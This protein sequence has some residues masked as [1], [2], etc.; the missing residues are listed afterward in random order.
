MSGFQFSPAL[1]SLT[2]PSGVT[3]IGNS[4]FSA[5]A[6]VKEYHILSTSVPTGGSNMFSNIASDCIIY[7]PAAKLSDYQGA[8][9]WST[10][11]SYMQGE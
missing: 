9:N 10:Y 7:V 8:S 4:A 11:A 3:S 1:A 5:C 6:G 2:I